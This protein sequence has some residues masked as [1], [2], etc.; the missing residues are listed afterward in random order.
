V[1]PGIVW[2]VLFSGAV[3]TVGFAFFFATENLAAQSVMTGALCVLIFSGLRI[4]VAIDHPFVGTV[5]VT[6]EALS[7]VLDDLG[8]EAPPVQPDGGSRR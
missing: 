2:F 6:P 3:V 7:A 4:I 1:V 8:S 5:K